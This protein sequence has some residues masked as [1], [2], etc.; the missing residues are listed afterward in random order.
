MHALTATLQAVSAGTEEGAE[1]GAGISDT[2][3]VRAPDRDPAKVL[4]AIECAGG[5]T[6]ADA[7]MAACDA[8]ALRDAATRPPEH[9]RLPAVPAEH[10]AEL[11]EALAEAVARRPE[12]EGATAHAERPLQPAV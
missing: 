2:G 10:L 1:A 6:I 8:L 4:V 12:D 3:P 9:M 7:Q 11:V 5:L